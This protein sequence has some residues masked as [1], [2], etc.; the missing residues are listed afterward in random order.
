M[1]NIFKLFLALLLALET[2]S[3][4]FYDFDKILCL[5]SADDVHCFY[6]LSVHFQKIKKPKTYKNI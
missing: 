5:F 2:S 4:L 3:R 1:A 6:C